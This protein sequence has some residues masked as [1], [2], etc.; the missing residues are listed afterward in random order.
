LF[1]SVTRWLVWFAVAC[2]L[3]GTGTTSLAGEPFALDPIRHCREKSAGFEG[4]TAL[5]NLEAVG[6]SDDVIRSRARLSWRDSQGE[7]RLILQM[8]APD[9]VAGSSILLI[10]TEGEDPEAWA[11]LP[12]IAKVKRVGR[13]HFR[14][15]LFGTNL[16]YEDLERARTVVASEA[17]HSGREASLDGRAV[18]RLEVKDGRDTIVSWLDPELCVPLR[19]EVTDRKGRLTRRVEISHEPVAPELGRFVPSSLT[20]RDLLE[21]TETRVGIEAVELEP[22]PPA[23]RFEPSALARLAEPSEAL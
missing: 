6:S 5:L 13:R 18:W 1:R 17:T 7:T 12:E 8:L 10:E 23:A 21:E 9:E 14:K 3:P 20:V 19:T 15:P 11:Y 4:G 16:R 22:A 2:V